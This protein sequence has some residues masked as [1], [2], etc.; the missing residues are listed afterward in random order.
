MHT[1]VCIILFFACSLVYGT[2]GCIKPYAPPEITEAASL[3]VV[4]G[5]LEAGA[6]ATATIKLSRTMRLASTDTIAPEKG[7][8]VTIESST[9][10]RFS[11]QEGPGGTYSA[12]G[13]ILQ[14][15]EKY[16][17]FIETSS[18]TQAA[19]EYVN[20][21]QTPPVDS[22]T[23]SE[24]EGMVTIFLDTH[25]P[26]ND[27]RYYRWTF[28]ETWEYQVPYDASAGFENGR[29]FFRDPNDQRFKCWHTTNNFS[30][31]L[32]ASASLTEDV[33]SKKPLFKLKAASEK[34]GV[35]YS[36]LVKQ[37]ALTKDAFDY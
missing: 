25:D 2:T 26:Q 24:E 22:L 34:L 36:I 29:L 15:S 27:T 13:L 12:T 20:F 14:P 32:G 8:R 17:L 23:W 18:G 19:S 10:Q 16:R 6:N 5:M 37:Y 21:K 28:D 3:L 9:Q 35:R 33:I 1:K 30:I 4:D 31:L 11:L 7:A